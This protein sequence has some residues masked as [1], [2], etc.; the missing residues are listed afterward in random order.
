MSRFVVSIISFVLFVCDR[1]MAEL[2]RPT[3][4]CTF[5]SGVDAD[6]SEGAGSAQTAAP[7]AI[8]YEAA[9]RAK[10][11]GDP[12]LVPG[13]V[14][15]ARRFD[16]GVTFQARRN[17]SP[18]RGTIMMWVQPSW[19]GSRKDLYTAFFGCKAWGLIYKYT[20]QD[21]ITFGWI[22][23]DGYFDYGCT[24]SIKRWRPGEWHH[25][26]VTYDA[27]GSKQRVLYLDG[28]RV[29]SR[30]IP[31]HRKCAAVFEIGAGVGGVNPAR[32]ALDELALFDR[33]LT[34]AQI[35][36]AFELGRQ[37]QPLFPKLASPRRAVSGLEPPAPA[38]RPPLPSFV[39]WELP[40]GPVVREWRQANQR[41]GRIGTTTRERVSLNGIWRFR[42]EGAKTWSYLHVPGSWHPYWRFKVRSANGST[43]TAIDGR[44]LNAVETAWYERTFVLPKGW[45]GDRVILGVDSVRAVGEVFLNGRRVGRALEFQRS[46]FDVSNVVQPGTNVL[47]IRVHVLNLASRVRGL[48]ED[49]WLERRPAVRSFHRG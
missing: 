10:A 4:Y 13:K 5:D 9:T 22:K 26:A 19:L 18:L 34:D 45:R 33:P 36:E 28:K 46:E 27:V 47:Q 35:A 11:T 29:R 16:A 44:P 30:I 38:P 39:N 43:V 40:A 21:F 42:P 2:P 24:G 25:I 41:G 23:E 15:R 32:A 17:F 48:D 37:S 6:F 7:D 12:R 1:G 31:S 8:L 49:V 3:F 14:G 20:T